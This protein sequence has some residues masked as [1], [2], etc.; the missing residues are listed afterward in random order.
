MEPKI[1]KIFLRPFKIKTDGWSLPG[2]VLKRDVN[3]CEA[4][5]I[6][7]NIFRIA[8]STREEL[9]YWEYQQYNEEIVQD[10]NRWL[11]GEIEDDQLMNE[12]AGDCGDDA[13]GAMNLIAVIQYLQKKNIL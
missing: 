5:H 11:R 10:V 1:K 2:L 3:L 9:E 12:Y 7:R 6:M 8:I 4:K 13:L